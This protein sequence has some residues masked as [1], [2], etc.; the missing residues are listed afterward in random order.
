MITHG[1]GHAAKVAMGIKGGPVRGRIKQSVLIK[2]ALNFDTVIANV[3]Q[4]AD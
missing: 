3:T 2:L 1:K 4:K